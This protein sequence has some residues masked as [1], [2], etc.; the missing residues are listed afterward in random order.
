MDNDKLIK[1]IMILVLLLALVGIVY[2]AYRRI[3][4]KVRDFSRTVFGTPDLAD[5]LRKM[6]TEQETTPKSVASATGLYLPS[7]MKDF[8]EFHFDEMRARA[9]NVL[10]SYLQSVD[11]LN[12]ALLTEGT[13]ELRDSLALRVETL[14]Q[15]GK[16]EHFQN[17]KIHRTEIYRYRKARGRCSILLQ[18]AIEYIHF[19]EKDG[20]VE[21]GRRDARE[22]SRYN[23]EVIYIQD[24]DLVENTTDAGLA[25]NCPSCGAPIRTLG[26]KKCE[27]CD[28]PLVEFNIRAWNFASVEEC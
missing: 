17:C 12:A 10:L 8:P 19:V 22:Q 5:G 24:R 1:I 7:I 28:S 11:A 9:E 15:T 13:D 26:A 2:F 18:S 21:K 20:S 6:E 27:Y 14:K 4:K 3:R 23:V 16:R 25:L